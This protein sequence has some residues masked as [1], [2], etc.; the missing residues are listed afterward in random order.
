VKK[1][2]ALMG[3]PLALNFAASEFVAIFSC[4]IKGYGEYA[5]FEIQ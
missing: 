2:K 3:Q 5:P 4:R 1:I